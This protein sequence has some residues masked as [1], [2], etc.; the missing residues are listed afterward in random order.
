MEK[1][2][3]QKEF[4]L[5][6]INTPGIVHHFRFIVSHKTVETIVLNVHIRTAC[7][8]YCT[9]HCIMCMEHSRHDMMFP[10]FPLPQ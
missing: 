10:L 4:V 3:Y 9:I 8:H 7:V 6:L 5:G 2:L 1:N